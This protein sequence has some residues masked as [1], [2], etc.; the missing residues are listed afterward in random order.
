MTPYVNWDT[1]EGFDDPVP[2]GRIA[3][4]TSCRAWIRI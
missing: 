4:S 2:T 1:V 3:R